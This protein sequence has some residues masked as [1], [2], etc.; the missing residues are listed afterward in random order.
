MQRK[1]P[2]PI[3]YTQI[4]NYWKACTGVHHDCQISHLRVTYRNYLTIE[5]GVFLL[6][7]INAGL[8]HR[9]K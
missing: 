9:Q 7:K 2:H 6:R 8:L 5:Q 3:I 4:F 1:S